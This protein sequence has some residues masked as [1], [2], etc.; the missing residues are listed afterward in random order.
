M[1]SLMSHMQSPADMEKFK[2][3][4]VRFSNVQNGAMAGV[5]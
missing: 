1:P 3:M 4:M 5:S 2:S